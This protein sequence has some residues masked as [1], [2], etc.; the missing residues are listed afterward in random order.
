MDPEMRDYKRKLE[1][2]KKLRERIKLQKEQRRQQMA[3]QRKQELVERIK[4]QGRQKPG[5]C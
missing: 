5:T 3:S 4:E 1:A 2:Q